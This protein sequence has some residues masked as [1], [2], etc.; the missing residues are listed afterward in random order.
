MYC[1][2]TRLHGLGCP[3]GCVRESD[4]NDDIDDVDNVEDNVN[5]NGDVIVILQ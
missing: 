3:P 2:T 5:N 1:D 4:R